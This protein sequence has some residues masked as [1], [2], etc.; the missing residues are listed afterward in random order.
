[1]ERETQ[2]EEL[3]KLYVGLTRARHHTVA[4]WGV[5]GKDHQHTG[6]SALGRLLMRDPEQRGFEDCEITFG[7]D[8]GE[9]P[10]PFARVSEKL[11]VLCRRAH[12]HIAWSPATMPTPPLARWTPPRVDALVT[13][14]PCPSFPGDTASRATHRS[15]GER[16]RRTSTRRSAQGSRRRRRNRRR[17]SPRTPNP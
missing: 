2:Q 9:S 8:A 11:D 3:R 14:A 4:W 13:D 5:I 1:L 10:T 7:K 15:R 12:D 6:Q 16:P 17:R